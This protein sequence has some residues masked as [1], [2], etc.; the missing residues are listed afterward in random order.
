MSTGITHIPAELNLVIAPHHLGPERGRFIRNLD[1][2]QISNSKGDDNY[3]VFKP[4]QANE[5]LD[6]SFILPEGENRCAGRY[7]SRETKEVY[8]HVWN[9]NSNH[10]IY[11]I[12]N[13]KCQFVLIDPKLNFQRNP[14]HFVGE[15]R[16]AVFSVCMG[17]K[18]KTI[19]CFTDSFNTQRFICVEDSI[20]TNFFNPEL[21]P[22]F[23][24]DYNREEL[25]SLGLAEPWDCIEVKEV[26]TGSA[27]RTNKIK[28]KF[29]QFRL[30][31]IDP[32]GRPAEDG[33]ISEPYYQTDC[34]ANLADCLDLTFGAGGPLWERI[35]IEVRRGCSTEWSYYDT[36]EKYENCDKEWY[37]R[38]LNKKINLDPLTNKITYRFCNDKECIPVPDVR[39]QRVENPLPKISESLFPFA[40]GLGLGGNT[41]QE[42]P[43]TC[44]VVDKI[45]FSVEKP[46]EASLP[47][48][49]NRTIVVWMVIHNPYDNKKMQPVYRRDERNVFGG[50]GYDGRE[51]SRVG[52][53]YEQTFG[54]PEQEG[55]VGILQGSAGGMITISKQYRYTGRDFLGILE[56]GDWVES[57]VEFDLDIARNE[58]WLQRFEFKNVPPGANIFRIL[59]HKSLPADPTSVGTSTYFA[60]IREVGNNKQPDFSNDAWVYAR[61]L[62]INKC[63]GDYDSMADNKIVEVEDLT[64]PLKDNSFARA[65]RVCAGYVY[66]TNENSQGRLPISGA[67]VAMAISGD[68]DAQYVRRTDYNGFFFSAAKDKDHTLSVKVQR[69]CKYEEV[70]KID[71]NKNEASGL[72]KATFFA[73]QKWA[74]YQTEECNRIRIK[75]KVVDCESGIGMPRMMVGLT[76]GQFTRTNL[77]GEYELI[78][79]SFEPFSMGISIPPFNNPSINQQDYLV[80]SSTNKCRITTCEDSPCLPVVPIERPDCVNCTPRII[81]IDD[82]L[83]KILALKERGLQL[84]GRYEFGIKVADWMGR[85]SFIQAPAMLEIPTVNEIGGFAFPIVNWSFDDIVFPAWVKKIYFT[86]TKNLRYSDFHTWVVDRF[87]LIDAAGNENAVAPTQIRVYY[88]SLN[89]YNK[90]NNFSTNSTWQLVDEKDSLRLTD[91]VH[92]VAN[93]DGAIYPEV[94]TE[95]VRFDKDGRYF[96]IEYNSKLADLKEGALIKFMR[97]QECSEVETHYEI[98]E[99]LTVI[100]GIPEKKNG[101]LNA[102]DSYFVNRQIPTPIVTTRKVRK[103]VEGSDPLVFEEVEES[104]T[105]NTLKSYGWPF[106]HHSPSDLWGTKCANRGRVGYKNEFAN[107]MCKAS[108]IALSGVIGTNGLENY[109]HYFDEARKKTFDPLQWGSIVACIPQ[110]KRVLCICENDHFIVPYDDNSIRVADGRAVVLSADKQFGSPIP[111]VGRKFGC[112]KDD[113]NTIGYAD[114]VAHWMDRT[115]NGNV[116]H[117]FAKAYDVSEGRWDNFL[118]KKIRSIETNGNEGSRYF[119]QHINPNDGQCYFTDF[120]LNNPVFINDTD[121]PK[122]EENETLAVDIATRTLRKFSSFT[123]EMYASLKSD[124]N[125]KQ[126]FSFKDGLPYR[127]YSS[128]PVLFNTFYGVKCQRYFS[129]VVAIDPQKVAEAVALEVYTDDI[130]LYAPRVRTQF[131]QVSKIPRN[132]FKRGEKFWVAPFLCDINSIGGNPVKN[133]FDGN[134]TRGRWIEILLAGDP[135]KLDQYS[136]L[137]GVIVFCNGVEKSGTQ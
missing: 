57:G 103:Q 128:N 104:E 90:Q 97:E 35:K 52:G 108:E 12:K 55:F 102:F 27:T 41:Y 19:Y 38:V 106:E 109:L 20:A 3:L 11:R 44:E 130:I 5:L 83:L 17:D 105:V 115:E 98:C 100:N 135:D 47:I 30:T 48:I 95:L 88:S 54:D 46:T 137:T 76:N 77:S 75:G 32:Y 84:G 36:I 28:Y 1:Y 18:T 121:S 85:K 101:V 53:V 70:G 40:G 69:Q 16:A 56:P 9:S 82:T 2:A 117:D 113:R 51:E 111:S 15:G 116:F 64:H 86:Y 93:G 74:S 91:T 31:Y 136:E 63:E 45:H 34:E 67:Q 7:V 114:G 132:W 81:A 92:F 60:S 10:S 50:L 42:K 120:R 24:G 68:A 118:R 39:T 107:V 13:G 129:I 33:V 87:E 89:E 25:F 61:E 65:T 8:V 78:T 59:G 99:T 73:T 96:N 66:E 72:K 62:F 26:K 6:P 21:F 49:A 122:I 29:L 43:L 125:D 123:P 22:R 126:F 23:K 37:E 112:Q 4:L 134:K 124:E 131:G 94:I 119:H 133:I 79:Y 110:P 127:H 80:F 58:R 71:W 14:R